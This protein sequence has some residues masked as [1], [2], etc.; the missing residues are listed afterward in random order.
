MSEPVT[1]FQM[2]VHRLGALENE[3]H[4]L[5]NLVAAQSALAPWSAVADHPYVTRAEN[6]LSGEP[7]IKGTRLTVQLILGLLAQ[8]MAIDDILAEYQKLTRED[9]LACL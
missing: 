3:V 2:V 9:I 6:I 4:E 7:I 1:D 5:H 8:G